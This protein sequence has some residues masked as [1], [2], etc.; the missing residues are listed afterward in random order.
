MHNLRV[1]IPDFY[2][3]YAFISGYYSP[4]PSI[5][6]Q[7]H[8]QRTKQCGPTLLTLIHSYFNIITTLILYHY[9]TYYSYSLFL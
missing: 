2:A 5:G 9:Q 6:S 1:I 7:E 8:L 4:L 3:Q